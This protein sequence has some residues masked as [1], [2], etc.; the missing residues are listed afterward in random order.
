MIDRRDALRV[1]AATGGAALAARSAVAEAQNVPDPATLPEP[2]DFGGLRTRYAFSVSVF[3]KERIMVDSP[4]SRAFVPAIG[5]EIWG[6]R[7]SG[8][9]VPYGGADFGGGGGP[10]DAHYMF[11]ADDGTPIYINNRGYMKR[12]GARASVE[13]TMRPRNAD[14]TFD[15]NFTAPADSVVPLRMRTSP[16]FEAPSDSAHAWMNSTVFI[17]HGL[18]RMDPDRT[19]FTYYEVL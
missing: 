11:R 7:L 19:V 16:Y 9:V 17:G 14:G 10:L 3:F 1:M 18:R 6:P 2:K 5:G 13:R 15:Q 12:I 8:I 4:Y